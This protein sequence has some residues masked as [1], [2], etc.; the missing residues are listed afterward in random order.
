MPPA[1]PMNNSL[2]PATY[3]TA[4]YQNWNYIASKYIIEVQLVQSPKWISYV[5]H[6]LPNFSILITG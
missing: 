4:Q 6:T 3:F 5:F 1:K 2:G